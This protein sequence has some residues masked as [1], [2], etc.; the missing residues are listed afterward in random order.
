MNQQAS[1]V[2][3]RNDGTSAAGRIRGAK[4]WALAFATAMLVA[5]PAAAHEFTAA[6]VS[7]GEGREARLAEAVRG[8]LLAADERDGHAGE[9]SD[10]HRAG[11]T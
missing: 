5:G 7:F 10:G 4:M 6:I 8:F 11:W 1:A 9:T 3:Y 2:G